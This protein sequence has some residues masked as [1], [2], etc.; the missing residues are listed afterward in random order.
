MWFGRKGLRCVDGDRLVYL[1]KRWQV[2]RL[3]RPRWTCWRVPQ[4]GWGVSF[5]RTDIVRLP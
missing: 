5:G 1:S 4:F 2:L 3:V